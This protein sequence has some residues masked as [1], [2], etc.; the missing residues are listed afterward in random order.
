MQKLSGWDELNQVICGII[1]T[2]SPADCL[3]MLSDE[4]LEHILREKSAS[5]APEERLKGLS[6]EERLKGLTAQ[7]LE[8]LHQVLEQQLSANGNT[9]SP[10]IVICTPNDPTT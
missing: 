10:W 4:Q 9:P 1:A 2:L 8:H 5:M 6:P 7:Q 3:K